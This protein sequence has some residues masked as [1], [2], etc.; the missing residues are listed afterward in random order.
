MKILEFNNKY[1]FKLYGS[2]DE[3]E[4]GELIQKSF[5]KTKVE[6]LCGKTTLLDLSKELSACSCVIG[7]DSGGMHLANFLGVQ[8]VVLFGPTNPDATR[9]IFGEN[10]HIITAGF[11]ANK[12]KTMAVSSKVISLLQNTLSD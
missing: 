7:N 9:P 2:A 5:S 8:T 6:N 1:H 11:Q 10:S 4:T 3:R 12:K